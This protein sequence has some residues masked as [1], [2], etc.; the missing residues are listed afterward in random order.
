MLTK[1]FPKSLILKI[2]NFPSKL[3]T[4][5]EFFINGFGY[6][7]KEKHQIYLSKKYCEEKHIDLS[8]IEKKG[9]RDCLLFKDFNTFMYNHTLHLR[10]K[11][12]YRYYLQAF[13]TEMILKCHIKDY[14]KINGKQEIIMP[15]KKWIC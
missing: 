8:S 15:K 11:Y 1:I 9:K 13:S 14:F 4:F 2:K 10:K 12:I 7:N 6:E 5:T 3:E